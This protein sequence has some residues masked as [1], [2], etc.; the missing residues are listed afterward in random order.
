MSMTRKEMLM[1]S[2]LVAGMPRADAELVT[3]MTDHIL[4]E[5]FGTMSRIVA[6]IPE[7]RHQM[8]VTGSAMFVLQR[9]LDIK[10]RMI[11]DEVAAWKAQ[12]E[13]KANG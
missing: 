3:D 5:M 2:G 11:K 9:E 10:L 13:K 7:P 4:D 1:K 6:T 12:D 8:M